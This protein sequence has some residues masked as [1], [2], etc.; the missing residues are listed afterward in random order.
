VVVVVGGE[1]VVVVGGEVVVVFR[2]GCVGL[3]GVV[4]PVWGAA[5]GE[6]DE[7]AVRESPAA[8]RASAMLIGT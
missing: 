4:A 8:P 1:V 3:E 7:Q 5:T 2:A 6:E